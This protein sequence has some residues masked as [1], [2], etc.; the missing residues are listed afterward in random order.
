MMG[1][2]TCLNEIEVS[3]NYPGTF[4]MKSRGKA[5]EKA[6]ENNTN[7]LRSTSPKC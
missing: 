2:T 6:M 1:K 4:A 5:A 3:L 7:E